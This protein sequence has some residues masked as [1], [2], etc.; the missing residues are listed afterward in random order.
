MNDAAVLD[1]LNQIVLGVPN[2]VGL[3]VALLITYM[4]Y[5]NAHAILLDRVMRLEN[6][7]VEL[8]RAVAALSALVES[9]T[10]TNQQ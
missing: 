7:L 1:L 5:R 3:G 4:A 9:L 10:R 2:F 8:T 6:S